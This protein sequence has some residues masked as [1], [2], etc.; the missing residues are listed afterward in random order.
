MFKIFRNSRKDEME[1]DPSMVIE[2]AD[3][4]QATIGELVE[5]AK[6]NSEAER[7][8]KQVEKERE[9]VNDDAYLDLDGEVMTVGDLKNRCRTK[10]NADSEEKETKKEGAEEKKNSETE[11][12][13]AIE[14]GV[15]KHM[16]PLLNARNVA[17]AAPQVQEVDT[18]ATRLERGKARYGN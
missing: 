16:K 18:P 6:K 5:N 8:P 17:Y 15:E 1:I 10:M 4:Q 13:N 3:G 14:E 12:Q 9:L 11:L 2:L 7:A